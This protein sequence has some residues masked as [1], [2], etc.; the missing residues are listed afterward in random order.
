[1]VTKAIDF[2]NQ[3]KSSSSLS[4]KPIDF[5]EAP[6]DKNK[7]KSILEI[8]SPKWRQETARAAANTRHSQKGGSHDKQSQIREIWAT[9]K[10][11]S[12]DLCAEQECA[13]LGMS[14]STA[15][16]A[17]RNT[18]EPTIDLADA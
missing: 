15:R 13:G 14:Y 2:L 8:G 10:Y 6:T 4:E 9:G 5:E 11:T 18:P 7:I 12:R 3:A 1:L 17:L 16:R